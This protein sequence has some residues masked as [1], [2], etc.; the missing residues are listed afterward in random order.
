M[1]EFVNSIPLDD[2]A[3]I[4]HVTLPIVCRSKQAA[5]QLLPVDFG[6]LPEPAGEWHFHERRWRGPVTYA[7]S[8]NAPFIVAY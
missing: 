3:E 4:V 5:G 1:Y 6:L 2:L 8:T 7:S